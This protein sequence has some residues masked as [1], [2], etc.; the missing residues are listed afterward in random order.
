MRNQTGKL[1][2]SPEK[3]LSRVSRTPRTPRFDRLTSA[4]SE[5]YSVPPETPR[6]KIS[7]Y[8]FTQPITLHLKILTHHYFKKSEFIVWFLNFSTWEEKK[9]KMH[10][11]ESNRYNR[12]YSPLLSHKPKHSVWIRIINFIGVPN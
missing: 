6:I 5:Y 3:R 10:F 2:R 7:S 12:F 11:Y 1:E 9:S 8:K 4:R